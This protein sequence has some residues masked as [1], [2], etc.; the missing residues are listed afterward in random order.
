M[1]IILENGNIK[2]TIATMGAEL[3]HLVKK[4]SGRDYMWSGDAEFWTG[5]SPVLF[6]IVGALKDGKMTLD[7]QAY[8]MKQHGFA[9]RCEFGCVEQTDTMAVFRLTESD[10]TLAQYPFS[11]QLDLKYTLV[12]SGIRIDYVVK[13]TNNKMMPF[14]IGTHP[15]FST[16][17]DEVSEISDWFIEFDL[18]ETLDRI[19]VSGGHLDLNDR[20][21]LLDDC[22]ILPLKAEDFFADAIVFKDVVSDSVTLKSDRTSEEVKVSYE[23]LPDVAF[24]QPKNAPFLCIEPW[25]GHTDVIG[26]DGTFY[27]KEPMIHL[28]AGEV[29]KSALVIE[30]N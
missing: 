10:A 2:A 6:P 21:R 14:Q 4:D 27:E 22:N 20:T 7:G 19:A 25:Y 28:G 17:T 5:R 3:I 12:E 1:E 8:E 30:I 23:N 29:S 15:A 18:K 16:V 24:W 11:F 26:F 9:R 13:N